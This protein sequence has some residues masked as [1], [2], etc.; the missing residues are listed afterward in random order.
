MHWLEQR[1]ADPAGKAY[2]ARWPGTLWA[3]KFPLP[4]SVRVEL[5]NN[6]PTT[7]DSGAPAAIDPK[8]GVL[9][10]RDGAGRP[11]FT[12]MSLAAHNQEIGHSDAPATALRLS[13]DW[14]GYFAARAQA[15]GG[16]MGIFLVSDNGSEEDPETVPPMGCTTG[17]QAQAKA[18]GETLADAVMAQVPHATAVQAG[19]VNLQ[20]RELY[21]PL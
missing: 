1:V 20:R 2:D 7:D 10:A 11:I 16:G 13:S 5:S 15:L 8:I 21:V 19:S 9:Q 18:T 12:L 4:P 6:F 17:C 3:S 14:P